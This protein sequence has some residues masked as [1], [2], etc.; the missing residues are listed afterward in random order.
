MKTRR[1][2]ELEGVV[3]EPRCRP[4]RKSESRSK[5][6]IRRSMK[7]KS[8]ITRATATSVPTSC[9]FSCSYFLILFFIL[10]FLPLEDPNPPIAPEPDAP[11]YA[12]CPV[13]AAFV[14]S[15]YLYNYSETLRL[16]PARGFCHADQSATLLRET[17]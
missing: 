7:M 6:R 1:E 10:P 17:T 5:T 3:N 14:F 11:G 13:A 8:T 16:L 15:G 4:V 2:G 12:P 9:S